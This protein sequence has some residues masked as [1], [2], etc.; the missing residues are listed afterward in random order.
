[1]WFAAQ[2]SRRR[3]DHSSSIYQVQCEVVKEGTDWIS[4]CDKG[5]TAGSAFFESLLVKKKEGRRLGEATV[6]QQSLKL[7]S[8]VLS[9][10]SLA[11]RRVQK[12]AWSGPT[13]SYEGAKPVV[14]SL[15]RALADGRR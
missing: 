15:G 7:S 2:Q 1:M 14:V 10:S 13:S 8:G 4:K 12:T 9:K 5:K 11:G 3:G 6:L